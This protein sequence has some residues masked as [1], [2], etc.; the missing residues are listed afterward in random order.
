M[1]LR[2][3]YGRAGTGKSYYCYKEISKTINA[4]E[5][6]YII[7]PEQFSFTAEKKLLN[8]LK[9]K[10]VINAEVLTFDRM[11]YRVMN[12]VGGATQV[13]LSKTGKA[14]LIYSILSNQKDNLK[15]LG[16]SDEN[17][18]TVGTVITEFKKHNITVN[19]LKDAKENTD[20]I[21]LKTKLGDI[22]TLYEKFQEAIQNNYIDEDDI[23]TILAAKLEK[24]D[25]FKDTIIYIDEF[26][27]FTNQEY[28][29]IE[30]LLKTA[31]QVNITVCTDGILPSNNM[32]TD[33]FYYNKETANQLLKIAKDVK[34]E[35]E[36]EIKLEEVNR[37]KNEEL[38]H[39][40]QNIYSTKYKKYEKKIDNI[41]LFLAMNQFSEIENIAKQ[42]VKLVRDNGYKYNDISVI[43]K[44]ISTYS[45]IT[46]AIFSKYN[47]PVFID[48]KKDLSQNILVKY[49]LA[50]LEIF[51][52][53]WSYEAMFNYI[54]TGLCDIKLEDIFFLENYCIKWGIKGSKWYKE[55]WKIANSDDELKRANELRK[56]I[57]NPLIQFKEKLDRTKTCTD[58]SRAIYEFLIEN[59][60]DVALNN[61][62]CNLEEIGEL[63]VASEYKT[64]WDTLINIL[65]EIVLVFKESRI[66]F[67]E[68]SKILKVGLQNSGL[69]KIPSTCDQVIMGDVDRSR[70]HKVKAVFILGLNDG[71]FP[72]INK[73][74]GFLND[75]DREYLKENGLE[76]AKGT[77]ERLYE[78]NFNIYKAF[79]I[80]E[81][82][83]YLSYASADN[84]G[85]SLRPSMLVSKIKK[86]FIN[87]Q[88]KSDI[89]KKADEITSLE[90]TFDE[91]LLQLR[92]FQDG[93]EINPIWFR[94]F[95]IYNNNIEWKGKL[96]AAIKGL[97]YTNEPVK[98]NKENVQKLYGDTLKTSIS[99]LEQY[100][101]CAFSF[102][103]KYGLKLSDKSLFQIQSL[104]TGTFMH[105]V[106]DEF[107]NQIVQREIN[108][109]G[110][111]EEQ[112]EQI[113]E[114]IINEKL[115][116]NR[117]YIFTST[118][119]FKILTMR[120]KKVIL[121]SMKY[122][123]ASIVE[124]DFDIFGNEVEFNKNA[125]YPPIEL[126]LENGKKVQITGKIDRIDLAKN[127][128]G[129]YVRII[130][131]KSSVKNIDLNEV[132]AGLQIQLLTYLDAVTKIEDLIPAGVLYF[133]LIDPIIKSDINM[134]D[135]EIELEIKKK[136]KMQ[137]L[138]LADVKVARMMDKK[139]EKGA[140]NIVPAYIDASENL[141]NTRSSTLTKEQFE[142][143]Q[144]YMN[145]ILKQIS[146]EILSG[147][148][149][150]KPYYNTKKKKTPC[151]YCEY[152]P[153][154]SFNSSENEYN[155]IGNME[156]EEILEM[157]Q[158]DSIDRRI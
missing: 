33:I 57:V 111:E 97:D 63:D 9:T 73:D 26:V 118:P 90:A 135:D 140:S 11:A 59:K 15:F 130:D 83:L 86:I 116:L 151:D 145:T 68:Y 32:D 67:E 119:K 149:D 30:K 122:I 4:K 132:I 138:I 150:L 125:K 98:L 50:L 154:C 131:Y 77:L 64:S 101:R 84:T 85:K 52:K 75:K 34:V 78:D 40:E 142:N 47:I 23:L 45:N 126:E 14:M 129:K 110:I 22:C 25:M 72:S 79:T 137:G 96:E 147:N 39:L 20:D 51:A 37:F 36:E 58:I 42:I 102:Y 107:F 124:S 115:T 76:L 106:I 10:A 123:I 87:I 93:E 43:T 139:L 46:K 134:T 31:Q 117:N 16:K 153:I 108:L 62:I 127:S 19:D 80:A 92:N 61:K 38:K 105:D 60:I 56:N 24:T 21:Y 113:V 74:E 112:V 29:I 152:K 5:K 44:N 121:K 41:E 88:E 128:D 70:T 66:S 17:I 69:G 53:S 12:E 7:T 28:K 71:I 81:E 91:L 143:L 54:K 100:K 133:N 1:S 99:R 94:I 82:K 18:D 89:I 8:S 114:S 146:K 65:D 109:R 141:S 6:I 35:I 95:N 158:A 48:E 27:G 2:L 155:Y 148:I 156:K 136:F 3:I 13:N 55:D 157:I 104:D 120:L 103:L 49:V 144:K